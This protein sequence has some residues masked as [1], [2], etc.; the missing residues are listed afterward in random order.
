MITQRV[1]TKLNGFGSLYDFGT[2]LRKL[3]TV[4]VKESF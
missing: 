4:M 1:R 2:A 3:G